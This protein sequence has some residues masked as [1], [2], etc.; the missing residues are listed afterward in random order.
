MAIARIEKIHL[1]AHTSVQEELLSCLQE[2][3]FVQLERADHDDLQLDR[4]VP[5]LSDVDHR[6]HRLSRAI[7][8]ISLWEDKGFTKKL[9][10]QKPQLHRRRREDVLD[11]DYMEIPEG[12]E[13]FLFF[14]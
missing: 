1:L 5:E 8:S 13:E 2:E 3:G 9:F 7:D 4:S 11:S 14:F 10:A 12:K 6:L